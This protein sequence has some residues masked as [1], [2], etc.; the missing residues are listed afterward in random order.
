M[1]RSSGCNRGCDIRHAETT[2]FQL[3]V[4]QMFSVARRTVPEDDDTTRLMGLR[5]V[6]LLIS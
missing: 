5:Q 3:T 2:I 1:R 4:Q 6:E